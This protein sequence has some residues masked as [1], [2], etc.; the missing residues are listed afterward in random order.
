[1]RAR[2][3][4]ND[5]RVRIYDHFVRHGR[6]PLAVELA[7][8]LDVS[9]AE[10]EGAFRRLADDHL[11]VL[12]PGTHHIWLANPLCA[13]PSPFSVATQGRQWWG[14]CIWDALGIL[15]MLGSDGTVSTACPDCSAPMQVGVRGG[16]VAGEGVVHYAVPAARWWDDIGFT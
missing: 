3:T 7:G 8:E 13:L 14:A 10:V 11:L 16:E 5:I 12:A 6:P 2:P 15:A 9:S 1:M 4:D